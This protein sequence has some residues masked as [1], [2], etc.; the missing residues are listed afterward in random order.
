METGH[1]VN[2]GNLNKAIAI[3]KSI[4]T[5]Y[6]PSNADILLAALIL[7]FAA[8]KAIFKIVNEKGAIWVIK[9][10]ARQVIFLPLDKILTQV[11]NYAA[12]TKISKNVLENIASDIKKIKGIRAVP[13]LKTVEGQPTDESVNQIS[14]AQTGIDHTINNLDA[15]I[16]ILIAE[17]LYDP[18][19][20]EITT[21]TL[22]TLLTDINSINDAVV[23]VFP[24]FD[25]ARIERNRLLYGV[26]GGK[27]LAD[28]V[29]NY[30]R[31]LFGG[32]SPQ[33][34]QIAALKFTKP[35]I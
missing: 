35:K 32:D 18:Q 11:Y 17:P 31:S 12:S 33:Y 10:K 7:H 28:H 14:A 19:E 16:Q 15:L 22:T 8:E 25:N 27:E 34:H 24:A 9:I 21:D 6:Q 5:R 20:T 23:D 2:H 30:I 3:V 4:G 26:G 13:K 29:K 1:V